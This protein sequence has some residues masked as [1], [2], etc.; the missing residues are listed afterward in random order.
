MHL[1]S[2]LLFTT[3]CISI[4]FTLYHATATVL[5]K[6]TSDFPF[7]E[8]IGYLLVL[9]KFNLTAAFD[10]VDHTL[11]ETLF[12]WHLGYSPGYLPTFKA[13]FFKSL[14]LASLPLPDLQ[15]LEFFWPLLMQSVMG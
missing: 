7:T 1:F 12:L 14:L 3:Q 4:R 8:P 11:L 6:V 10:I 9:I 5:T 13:I 2:P 15:M